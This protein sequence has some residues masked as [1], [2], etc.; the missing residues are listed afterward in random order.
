M[1]SELTVRVARFGR[2]YSAAEAVKVGVEKGWTAK[3]TAFETGWDVKVLQTYAS[4]LHLS[5]AYGGKGSK[6]KYFTAIGH[7]RG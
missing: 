5:F 6:P 4:R 7:P 2:V 3:E 1:A